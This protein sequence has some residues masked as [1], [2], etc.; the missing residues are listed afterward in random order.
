M[1]TVFQGGGGVG[2]DEFYDYAWSGLVASG[3]SGNPITIAP[4]VRS[5]AVQLTGTIAG[6]LSVAIQGS[7]DNVAYAALKDDSGTLIALTDNTVVKLSNAP[8]FIKPVA[9]AGSG[10]A[11]ATV[12]LHGM[13]AE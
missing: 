12:S 3:D 13:V 1:A 5:V 9:T 6:S 2:P 11:A 8:K 10:G 7:N 4:H